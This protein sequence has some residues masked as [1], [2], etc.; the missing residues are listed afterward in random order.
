MELS[1]V[2]TAKLTGCNNWDLTPV[3][4]TIA[5]ADNLI[6]NLVVPPFGSGY[7]SPSTTSSPTETLDDYNNGLLGG[8]ADCPTPAHATSWGRI[9]VLYR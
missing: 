8:V 3:L 9:K 5:G 1:D 7:L 2:I 4:A 6:G